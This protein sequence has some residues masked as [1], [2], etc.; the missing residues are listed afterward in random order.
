MNDKNRTKY[1][2]LGILALEP[3][4]GYAINKMIKSST[5]HFWNESPGQIYPAFDFKYDFNSGELPF[6]YRGVIDLETSTYT[7]S[8]LNAEYSVEFPSYNLA[9]T[10]KEYKYTYLPGGYTNDDE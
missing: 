10:A 5:N 6:L 7:H 3:S 4:T 9:Y 1:I 2:V 8:C